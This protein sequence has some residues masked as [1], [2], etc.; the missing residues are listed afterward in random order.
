MSARIESAQTKMN[1][2]GTET[3]SELMASD[4]RALCVFVVNTTASF[5]I[6]HSAAATLYPGEL[7]VSV[8]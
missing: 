4:L 6:F 3:P 1:H 5:K 8:V 7:G 2:R